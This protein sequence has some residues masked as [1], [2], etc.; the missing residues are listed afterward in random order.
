MDG[1]RPFAVRSCKRLFVYGLSLSMLVLSMPCA[2]AFFPPVIQ[3]PGPPVTPPP[4]TQPPVV[5]PPVDPPPV[6][7]PPRQVPE[8]A[9][10]VT[11]L[12][13]L[14]AAAGYHAIR[15]KRTPE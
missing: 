1:T 6:V 10:I 9:T 15:R 11:A 13:G 8:P 2:S 3:P 12:A 7:V 5:V 4:S 14:A